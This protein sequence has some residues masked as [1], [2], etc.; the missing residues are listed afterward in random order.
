MAAKN[1]NAE[2]FILYKLVSFVISTSLVTLDNAKSI[3]GQSGDL[4]S[5]HAP[6]ARVSIK[7]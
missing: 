1:Q 2:L 4:V 5:N 6:G 3:N 7:V